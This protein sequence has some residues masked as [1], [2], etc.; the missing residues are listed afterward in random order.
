MKIPSILDKIGFL[1]ERFNFV[2][3]VVSSL[4]SK[5]FKSIESPT[6]ASIIANLCPMQIRGP[7]PKIVLHYEKNYYEIFSFLPNGKNEN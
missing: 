4:N 1:G 6:F 3:L 7:S 2:V 5:F